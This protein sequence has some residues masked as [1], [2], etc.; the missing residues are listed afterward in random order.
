MGFFFIFFYNPHFLHGTCFIII[1]RKKIH[2]YIH[3]EWRSVL[4]FCFVLFFYEGQCWRSKFCIHSTQRIF[5]LRSHV[6]PLLGTHPPVSQLWLPASFHWPFAFQHTSLNSP[7]RSSSPGH[8]T[9]PMPTVSEKLSTN[10]VPISFL[11]EKP[12][13][14]VLRDS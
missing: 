5:G 4:G 6:G 8:V 13:K 7:F 14:D 12:T 10:F 1:V 3:S 11:E 9:N 2:M